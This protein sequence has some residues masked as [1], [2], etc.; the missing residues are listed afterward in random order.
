[1][2]IGGKNTRDIFA[3]PT[4]NRKS[5][6]EPEP[7]TNDNTVK[8]T[9]IMSVATRLTSGPAENGGLRAM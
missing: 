2:R 7:V 8:A 4:P 6:T 9:L 5:F 1:M 3:D